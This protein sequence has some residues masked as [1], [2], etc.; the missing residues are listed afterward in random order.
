MP[1]TRKNETYSVDDLK[2]TKY[3]P[4]TPEAPKVK[5]K[6]IKER[7]DSKAPEYKTDGSFA[8]DLYSDRDCT[9]VGNKPT[10]ISLGVKVEIP[11]GYGMLIIPRSSIGS[12]TPLRQSNSVGL[13]DSDYRG[14]VMVMYESNRDIAG[15]TIV[16]RGDR[17]AQG[18]L[19]PYVNV[20]FVE[21]DELSETER[22]TG[23]FGSTGR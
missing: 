10:L 9:V 2:V 15:S 3:E 21:A 4:Y 5:V 18:F 11:S 7:P 17:I 13:I 16:R 22:G 6:F 1:R 23:G 14:V 20:D 12:K 19:I 8:F